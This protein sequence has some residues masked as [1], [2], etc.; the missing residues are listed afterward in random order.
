M[1]I[2]PDD[3]A[4][5]RLGLASPE[6]IRSWSKGEVTESETIN[7]RTHKPERGGLFA[8]EIFG[9]VNDYEC[10]CGKYKGRK[11][12]GITCEKCGVLVTDSGIRRVNMGHIELASPVVHFWYLKGLSSPLSTL[13]GIKRPILKRIAYYETEPLRQEVFLVTSS[14]DPDLEPGEHLYKMEYEILAAHKEFRA[15]PAYK[16]VKAPQVVA[17]APGEVSLERRRLENGEEIL[18]VRVGELEYP[19]SAGAELLVEAGASVEEG[20]PLAEAPTGV[21]EELISESKYKLF[22]GFYPGFEATRAVEEVDNLLFLVTKV[23]SPEI[24]VKV[25][26]IIWE[27]EKRAYELVFKGQFEAHTGALGIKGVLENL[28][29]DQLSAQLKREIA[30]ESS[31][32]QRARLLKRLEIVEQLRKSGNRPQDMVIEVLPVLPPSL[33]PIVQLEGGKFATTDLND[34][35]RRIINRNNRLKKLMEMGAP[36][37]ILRNERRMLQEAVDALI[38]NEKKDNPILGRDN[39]PLKSLSERISGKQGRLRRNLLGR[40]VDYSGRAVIVVNPKLKLHQCGLPKKIALE[41]FKPF[42][43][44]ELETRLITNYDE[45]KNKALS[46]EMPEVWDIL[47]RL[48]KEHPVLLNRAPTLHRLG[49]QAFEPVL[50]D[51]DAIQIHPL[52]CP[53]Y[54]AD[55]DGD[56]MAVHLPL[57]KEA[58]WESRELMLSSKNILSPAHGGPLTK[59]TQDLIFAY[60]Y[61][62]I[63]DPDGKGKGKAFSSVR[64]AERAWEEGIIDLHAPVKIRVDGK[65]IE[66]T[67]G[68][69]KF[70]LLLPEDLRDYKKVFNAREVEQL[71]MECYHRHGL[72]RTVKLLDDLKDLGFYF[73][74]KS[75]L[76]ISITDCLIPPEKE[77]ILKESMERVQRINEQYERGLATAEERREAVI[78][79]WREAVDR[80]REVTMRN[81][82]KYPFNPVW[83]IV[84]SG[85]RGSATQVT[86]LSGMRGPMAD[87]TGRIIEMPVK[88]NFREGLNVIEYFISTHGGR[89]GTADTALKTADSGYLTR[90]LVD[91]TEELIVK[92]YDC[93]TAGGI[94]IDPLYY[95]RGEVMETIEERIYGRVA[96]QTITYD[97]KV[98]LEKGELIGREKA[99][100]LANLRFTVKTSDPRFLE[101]VVGTKSVEDVRDP[102]TGFVIVKQDELINDYLAERLRQS[103]VEEVTV[104]PNIVVRSPMTCQTRRGVC[105]LCYGL[106]LSNHR[107]VELGTAVG[108]IAAQSIGEPGTQLTM[109]TFHTGGVAGVDITQGLPRAEELFE[110][111]K[112]LRSAEGAVAPIS[113][114]VVAI[115]PTRGGRELVR[116]R[117]EE[118]QVTVPASLCRVKPGEEV[119]LRDLIATG[120][121]ASGTVQLIERDG[122]RKLLIINEAD[123]DRIYQVPEGIKVVVQTGQRVEEGTPL[124]EKFNEEA[125]VAQLD[126]VVEEVRGDGE[127]VVIIKGERGERVPHR[128]PYGARRQV[129]VGDRVRAGDK[130]STRSIPFAIKAERAGQVI[131]QDGRV[132]VYQPGE[133]KELPLTPDL[134]LLKRE[135]E[136]VRAG[137]RL[138]TL[139]NMPLD[140]TVVVDEVRERDREGL[141]EIHFHYEAAVEIAS[142]P[143]VRVGD[144]V[145]GGDLVSKGV[146]SPHYLLKV[147]GVEKTREYLL[148]EIHKVYKSQGVDINDKHIELVIKQMLNNVRIDDPGDSDFFPNQLVI[149]EEFNEV[150][151]RLLR[152]NREIRRSREE[153]VGLALAEDALTPDG[154]LIAPKGTELTEALLGK[155][156]EAGVEE[157]VVDR[158][159]GP[160][161]VR[162]KEWRLPVGERVLL[163]ISKAALETKSF[164][165]A[166]SFQRTTTVLAEAAL[167]GEV[168]RLEGLKPNVILG[169]K[170]PAGTAVRGLPLKEKVKEEEEE[171][172]EEKGEGEAKQAG[173]K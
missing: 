150:R 47:D 81:F 41:L 52:V 144:K 134:E 7:Y 137:E 66:T 139:R 141:A 56:Q 168:D 82:S 21:G 148:T 103:K 60:Y 70:N 171:E 110:A 109:R 68:R 160:E 113:G 40:R 85:A 124:T 154:Q 89:K 107:L 146:T 90:R 22:R 151:E 133:G 169:R 111:R 132:I 94:E 130:L 145:R 69:V 119:L 45:I 20:T 15:E 75:G 128:I 58:I 165:S 28:D 100:E 170:I 6:E 57:S 53:P 25:G 51:G 72:E 55:F 153:L 8:E 29:L 115:E 37:V 149:L 158:G 26:D 93:G 65:L 147:A 46:G 97:G 24:P 59:P 18:L 44:R 135:G 143:V 39:R 95:D 5:V 125:A 102:E 54:N 104:R 62:T 140:R 91:A 1:I 23:R 11:F 88:S 50:V 76:T 3:I 42:I 157:V 14:D 99:R 126:G 80:V 173:S 86:Q 63:E 73:A 92:E 13:L 35:Y 98:L 83:G 138:F 122:Q 116:I 10:A 162:I 48:I 123:G 156:V 105:Q 87:P 43:L 17:Q 172:K 71:I 33:R 4:Y 136:Q 19:L 34:L 67:L 32:A 127:R 49:I 16:V 152:E 118:R 78:R 30:A 142:P 163:R 120:S 79:V 74:T 12:E 167:R 27:L 159:E 108:V 61:L 166:A 129:E 161:R 38:H 155:L 164:L 106:D 131:V 84:R 96:A 114:N 101:R 64:E 9:P 117:G 36:Q 112:A 31:E 77:E 2:T 121:P